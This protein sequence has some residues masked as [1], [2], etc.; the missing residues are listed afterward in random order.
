MRGYVTTSF[1]IPLRL[2]EKLD[3]IC[4]EDSKTVTS[5]IIDA[6]NI[7]L[8]IRERLM[9][10]FEQKIDDFNSNK[11]TLDELS[12]QLGMSPEL[13]LS[14]IQKGQR[15]GRTGKLKSIFDRIK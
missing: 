3:I 15:I 5:I 1:N 4:E 13:L 6:L 14:M 10:S 7:Y 8:R 11:I 9:E 12:T 2:K